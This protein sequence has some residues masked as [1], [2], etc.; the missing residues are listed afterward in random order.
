MKRSFFCVTAVASNEQ[1]GCKFITL[2]NAQ[3]GKRFAIGEFAFTATPKAGD[4]LVRLET[5]SG[6]FRGYRTPTIV[7]RLLGRLGL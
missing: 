1:H 3:S 4:K 7:D 6:E 2:K 5:R